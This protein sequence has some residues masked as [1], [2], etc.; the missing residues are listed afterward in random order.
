MA[1]LRGGV[2]AL[3]LQGGKEARQQSGICIEFLLNTGV[4]PG[5]STIGDREYASFQANARLIQWTRGMQPTS[6]CVCTSG[7]ARLAFR[8]F[9][10]I[11][12]PR[13]MWVQYVPRLDRELINM[14]AVQRKSS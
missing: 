10:Q 13:G 11:P 4:C 7:A 14:H 9:Q 8:Y 12:K 5:W 6:G 2:I 3:R 1:L